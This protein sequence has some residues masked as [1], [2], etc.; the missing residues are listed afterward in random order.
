MSVALFFLYVLILHFVAD[1]ILQPYW[2]SLEK[3]DNMSPLILHIIIYT[4]V[5]FFGL[6]AVVGFMKSLQFSLFSAALHFCVDFIT[7]RVISGNSGSLKLDPDESKPVHR[8]LQLWGPITLL[9]FDQLLHQACLAYAV[10]L[11]FL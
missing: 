11:F 4:T 3:A 10:H 8:R 5:L 2:M 7:S 1:F 6:W 9:G